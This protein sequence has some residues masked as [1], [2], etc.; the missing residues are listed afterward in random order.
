VSAL[1]DV[2][3]RDRW[4]TPAWLVVELAERYA[5]EHFDL[6]AAT[7]PGISHATRGY[8]VED[9]GLVLPW[10]GRVFVNPPYSDL[11]PWIDQA[12]A[13]VRS[14]RARVVVMLLPGGRTDQRWYHTLRQAPECE[15]IIPIAGRVAFD[16]PPGVKSSQNREASIVAVLR[17][18]LA[19][20]VTK[21]KAT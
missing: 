7:E 11:R 17:R 3:L 12:L 4:R 5:G 19:A 10:A 6:D 16:P 2:I 1:D 20:R 21:K 13:E 14:G 18:P 8:M 9:D 15:I